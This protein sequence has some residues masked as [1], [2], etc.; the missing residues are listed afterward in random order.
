MSKEISKPIVKSAVQDLNGI[1]AKSGKQA[2]KLAVPAVPAALT[3]AEILLQ[4]LLAAQEKPEQDEE[5]QDKV[6]N[7]LNPS[8][9][10]EPQTTILLAQASP[11]ATGSPATATDAGS[12]GPSSGSASTTNTTTTA[13]SAP[14]AAPEASGGPSWLTALAGIA[15]AGVAAGGSSDTTPP[16]APKVNPIGAT[17]VLNAA[18]KAAGVT[19]SG[20]A[21]ANSVVTVT[22]GGST[23]TA[24][25]NASGVWT[26]TFA[27]TS[28]PADGNT[29]VVVSAKDAAGNKSAETT[30]SVRIDATAP[31]A[32]VITAVST[33]N[34]V[35]ASEKAAGVAVSG[36]AEAGA[37]VAITWGSAVKTVTAA[38][39]GAFTATFASADIPSDAA[40]TTISAVATDA[41]GNAGAA[42]TKAVAV[43]TVAPTVSV[44]ASNSASKTITL[45]YSEALNA[46]D[47]PATT[48]FSVSIG[49][50]ANP[51]SSVAVNGTTLVLT[52]TNAFSAG[53]VSVAY[54]DPTTGNDTAAIQ[55]TSGNDAASF[56]NTVVADGYI[57]GATVYIDVNKNGVVDVGTDFLVGTTDANGNILIP[58]S[59]PAGSIIATGGVNMDT[60]V[61][62]TMVLKAPQG[63]AT[64]NPL[65]TLVQAVIEKAVA[66]NPNTVVDAALVAQASSKVADSLGLT[67]N[68]NGAS[69]MSYDPIAKGDTLVQKAA[70]QV[71]T[72]VSLAG[73]A[74]AGTS[75]ISKLTDTI[76]SKTSSAPAI[77]LTNADTLTSILPS[78]TSDAVKTAINAA[79]SGIS[80]ATSLDGITNAQST[81][82][83]KTAPDAPKSVEFVAITKDAQP[84]IKISFD[85]SKSDGSALIAGNTLTI[86]DGAA[87]LGSVITL[88][89]ED[90]AKGF[91]EVKAPTLSE[92]AHSITALFTDKAGNA[93]A[94]SAAKTLTVDLTAP[95]K[96]S[97]TAFSDNSGSAQDTLT[98]DATPSLTISAEAGSTVEVFS[99]DTLLGKATETSTAGVF[100]FTAESQK[101]GAY[102]FT[103]KSSDA[104]GNS[105]TSSAQAITIDT[106]KP[107]APVIRNAVEGATTVALTIAGDAGST[108]D[109]YAG[110]TKLGSAVE[111][112]TTAG[113]F[114][115]AAPLVA[116]GKY[117]LS[118]KASDAAGNA[119]ADSAAQS[120]IFSAGQS[121]Q[122]VT[123]GSV[124]VKLISSDATKATFGIYATGTSIS[125][126][127]FQFSVA[128]NTSKVSYLADTAV[129]P[130]SMS[131]FDA[132]DK[133]VVSFAG[134]GTN[135]ITSSSTAIVTFS[136]NWVS[137]PTSIDL[138]V[139]VSSL[140]GVSKPVDPS[141][142]FVPGSG[143]GVVG[144][145][146]VNDTFLI[147]S[148]Q[149]TLTG[150]KG[151]DVFALTSASS[152]TLTLTDFTTGSD[153]IDISRLL[154]SVGYTST[155]DTGAVAAN[156][157]LLKGLTASDLSLVAGNSATLDNVAGYVYEAATSGTNK[158]TLKLVFDKN[159][160][161]GA[162]NV[163][164]VQIDIVLG[165]NSTG[166]TVTDLITTTASRPVL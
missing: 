25:T 149:I 36:T 86:K 117:S 97:I 109:V 136:L 28:V 108:I 77:S 93:S 130:A 164:L 94:A 42:G 85:A 14:P 44:L 101:D 154:A 62:N 32:P 21:E 41:V 125:V 78:T 63:A 166:F 131:A 24:T 40:S 73:N 61:A 43:D 74:E 1:K 50:V 29:N 79:T 141:F 148:G 122:A 19:V 116:S 10:Q 8:E 160:A 152:S 7:W 27:A 83:D 124:E 99:G 31:A 106:A 95:V 23:A 129:F 46:T 147:G 127:E 96:P 82:I 55:D 90:I 112:T 4:K 80:T 155:K 38:A 75:V 128:L 9:D 45:T 111:S 159:A 138:P 139:T 51:V 60:G 17:N 30:V 92:G 120:F 162:E 100:S 3:E 165:A 35:N 67:A 110:S 158:G 91:V 144:A 26:T 53:A 156:V 18:A 89:A 163:S 87:V 16:D 2:G 15:L 150:G 145:D 5:L 76:N 113:Q 107:S 157:A 135:P 66:A 118:A 34:A 133:G 69:L 57:R 81:A 104:A 58:G 33:D 22:W 84:T 72:I 132:Y 11:S 105:A 146:D 20:T 54:T 114:T 161:V 153:T 102:T 119:S 48:A 39:D 121:F 70:A 142:K 65:T 140:A 115:Y 98:N 49:G 151:A 12:G 88:T 126:D 103:A 137:G 13:P 64:I 71:A 52:L 56:T 68:L 143:T 123:P 59:A 47:L 134:F 37:S 6:A